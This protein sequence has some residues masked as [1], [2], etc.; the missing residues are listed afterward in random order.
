MTRI[1][2]AGKMATEETRPCDCERSEISGMHMPLPPH[3]DVCAFWSPER[4]H[5]REDLGVKAA[6]E[7]RATALVGGF[8]FGGPWFIDWGNHELDKHHVP[9][10]CFEWIRQSDGMFVWLAEQD[11]H[12][13][14]IE[15]GFAKAIGKPLFIAID[16]SNGRDVRS[17]VWFAEHTADGFAALPSVYDAWIVFTHWW[18]AG[19]T[20]E[21]APYGIRFR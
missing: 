4:K 18:R 14:L 20:Q 16:T 2:L 21:V 13:T 17:N 15:A 3:R 10:R 7:G 11:A 6:A 19:R 9:A 5:W 8:T 1:Y 12:G